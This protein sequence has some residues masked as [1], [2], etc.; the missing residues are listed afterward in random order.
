MTKIFRSRDEETSEE[1]CDNEDD[2]EEVEDE[3]EKAKRVK[4]EEEMSIEREERLKRY[5]AK[6]QML[7]DMGFESFIRLRTESEKNLKQQ[8]EENQQL[9]QLGEMDELDEI[10][11]CSFPPPSSVP[12]PSPPHSSMLDEGEN[13]DRPIDANERREAPN[14]LHPTTEQDNEGSVKKG[15]E[16]YNRSCEKRASVLTQDIQLYFKEKHQQMQQQR[17]GKRKQQRDHLKRDI[18]FRA[19]TGDL[20]VGFLSS[21]S[22][23]TSLNPSHSPLSRQNRWISAK[24]TYLKVS[25]RFSTVV[26][27]FFFFFMDMFKNYICNAEDVFIPSYLFFVPSAKYGRFLHRCA[28]STESTCAV[29][30]SACILFPLSTNFTL[31]SCMYTKYLSALN[32]DVRDIQNDAR[33]S[34]RAEGISARHYPL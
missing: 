28:P 19:S 9:R 2:K 23:T 10:N 13:K 34:S 21:S 33:S 15:D 4:E 6:K 3:E 16:E 5:N 31:Q 18:S 27:W 32:M 17:K 30:R 26:V 1:D 7:K 25:R 14:F 24:Y 8:Q 11:L 12:P 20:P 29:S 22:S